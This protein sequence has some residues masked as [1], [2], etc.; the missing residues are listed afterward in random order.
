LRTDFPILVR[1]VLRFLAPQSSMDSMQT[2]VAYG[3]E[4]TPTTQTPQLITQ[5]MFANA[6]IERHND[7]WYLVDI[8]EIGAYRID[9]T[10]YV[11]NML[12]PWES[13][14]QRPVTELHT[15]LG[16]WTWSWPLRNWCIV[17]AMLLMVIERFLTW[18]T[19]RTT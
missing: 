14:T 9:T 6:R 13:A 4:M 8:N 16:A 5:P 15:V 19:G 17:V 18:Y 12:A 7:R 3:L 11:A 2:G 1:N 10:W